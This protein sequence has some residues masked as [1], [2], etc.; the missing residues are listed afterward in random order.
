[1]K[2]IHSSLPPHDKILSLSQQCDEIHNYHHHEIKHRVEDTSVKSVWCG[3]EHV[4]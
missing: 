3:E 4:A 1:M 2:H